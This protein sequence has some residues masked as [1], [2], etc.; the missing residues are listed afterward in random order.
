MTGFG[1]HTN[2]R[3]LFSKSLRYCRVCWKP[4]TMEDRYLDEAEGYTYFR[5]PHCGSSYPVRRTDVEAIHR[6]SA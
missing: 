1:F 3:A 5:C 6:R 2:R 4:I